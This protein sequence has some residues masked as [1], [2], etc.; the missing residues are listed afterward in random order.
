MFS[1]TRKNNHFL[2]RYNDVI[3]PWLSLRAPAEAD[4]LEEDDALSAALDTWTISVIILLQSQHIAIIGPLIECWTWF[5]CFWSGIFRERD[6]CMDFG[7]SKCSSNL[8]EPSVSDAFSIDDLDAGCLCWSCG[9]SPRRLLVGLEPLVGGTEGGGA[10][11][12]TAYRR[13]QWV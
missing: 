6:L 4:D 13:I 7:L 12:L 3:D 10:V 2:A 9:L 1:V 11:L 5:F 8:L